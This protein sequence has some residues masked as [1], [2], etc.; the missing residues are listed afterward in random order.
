[1]REVVKT[2]D[3]L[4]DLN[5]MPQVA[6]LQSV[7]KAIWTTDSS[8][9]LLAEGLVRWMSHVEEHLIL[10]AVEEM[11]DIYVLQQ[12]F[13]YQLIRFREA[14]ARSIEKLSNINMPIC[15]ELKK[16]LSRLGQYDGH[17]NRRVIRTA[18]AA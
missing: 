8:T 13:R 16:A 7:G 2:L 17:F 9:G 11:Q 6:S 12:V 1:M 15:E 14:L 3:F 10:D 4:Q 5:D 18:Q